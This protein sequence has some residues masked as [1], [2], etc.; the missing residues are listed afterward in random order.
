MLQVNSQVTKPQERVMLSR[1]VDIMVSL[2][3]RLIQDKT[4]DGQLVYRLDPYVLL[5]RIISRL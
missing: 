4:E 1:L 3:L 5:L 2:E